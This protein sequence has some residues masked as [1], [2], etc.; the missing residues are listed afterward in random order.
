M[1]AGCEQLT[2]ALNRLDDNRALAA[3]RRIDIGIFTALG[4]LALLVPGLVAAR[5]RYRARRNEA[6]SVSGLT[7]IVAFVLLAV[8]PALLLRMRLRGRDL[9]I[10]GSYRLACKS[11]K[12]KIATSCKPSCSRLNILDNLRQRSRSPGRLEFSPTTLVFGLVFMFVA[13]AFFS[14]TF[15]RGGALPFRMRAQQAHEYSG[16]PDHVA[17]PPLP[18]VPRVFELNIVTKEEAVAADA[19]GVDD[20]AVSTDAVCAVCLAELWTRPV[21]Q[22]PCGHRFHHT[23]AMDWLAKAPVPTCPLCKAPVEPVEP[24]EEEQEDG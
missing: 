22:L 10:A 12:S 3:D 21:A 11:P 5:R 13:L 17:V 19:A 8:F 7:C 9:K 2:L 1:A 24:K 18:G 6:P 4:V 16:S 15:R 14:A 23:C 20:V